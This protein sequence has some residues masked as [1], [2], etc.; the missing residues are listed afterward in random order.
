MTEQNIICTCN[1]STFAG[2]HDADCP[3]F[4]KH[5]HEWKIMWHEGYVQCTGNGCKKWMAYKKAEARL[6]ATERLEG[7]RAKG[8]AICLEG[9]GCSNYTDELIAYADTLEGKR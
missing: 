3:R 9:A 6:N 2:F 4:T 5:V 7:H 8:A 1:H